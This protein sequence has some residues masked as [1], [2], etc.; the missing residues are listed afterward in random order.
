MGGRGLVV[1]GVVAVIL[2]FVVPPVGLGLGAVTVFFAARLMRATKPQEQEL[3]TPEGVPVKVKLP[4][5]GRTNAVFGLVLGIAATALGVLITVMLLAFWT[6]IS[7]YT[8]GH[9]GV[10]TTQGE[11]KCMDTFKDSVREKLGQ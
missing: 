7:D 4:Q 9:E 5:P 6:E 10:N 11:S 8:T 1:M 2:V 3:L